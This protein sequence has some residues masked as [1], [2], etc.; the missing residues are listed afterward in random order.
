MPSVQSPGS[1]SVC[2]FAI[3]FAMPASATSSVT[4][5]AMAAVLAGK[6]IASYE[7]FEANSYQRRCASRLCSYVTDDGSVSRSSTSR[8]QNDASGLVRH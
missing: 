6:V 8:L 4:S 2:S 5:A 7:C 1:S 3:A